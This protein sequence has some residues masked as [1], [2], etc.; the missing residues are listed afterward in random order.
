[1][2]LCISKTH[3]SEALAVKI[4]QL[5]LAERGESWREAS[6]NSGTAG[7]KQTCRSRTA[8]SVGA[9]EPAIR[10]RSPG[11]RTGGHERRGRL[12]RLRRRKPVEP[13]DPR[14]A[15]RRTVGTR[16]RS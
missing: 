3:V 15:T 4:C 14:V 11:G 9:G 7:F 10:Y 2:R 1:M 8:V 5:A 16:T 13:R 6:E 12:G